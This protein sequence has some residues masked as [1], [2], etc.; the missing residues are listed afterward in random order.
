M[1]I[2]A[3]LFLGFLTVNSDFNKYGNGVPEYSYVGGTYCPTGV[4]ESGYARSDY[5]NKVYLKQVHPDGTIGPVC[6]T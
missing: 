6:V 5:N 1:V 3:V 4:R 2:F